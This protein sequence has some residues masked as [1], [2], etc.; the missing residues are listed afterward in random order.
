MENLI[1][2]YILFALTTSITAALE[3]FWPVLSAIRVY[4]PELLVIKHRFMTLSS[5]MLLAFV[6]APLVFL[7]CIVPSMGERFRKSLQLSL[8]QQ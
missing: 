4:A 7:P 2:C 1:L 8:E 6:A 3:L 5:L